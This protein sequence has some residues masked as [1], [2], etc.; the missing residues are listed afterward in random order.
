[1]YV[2]REFAVQTAATIRDSKV[3]IT[4]EYEHNALRADGE[5]IF[6]RLLEMARG[7]R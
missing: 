7:Q 2:A 1:M 3:W 6:G 5:V 4:N